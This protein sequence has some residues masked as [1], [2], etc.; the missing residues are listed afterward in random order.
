MIVVA[1]IVNLET[2][3][4]VGAFPLEYA[5]SRFTFH[6][7]TDRLG[8]VG[9]NV[10]AGIGALGA[11][12]RLM[13][14]VGDDVVGRLLRAELE[15]LPGVDCSALWERAGGSLRSC[16][17]VD[18]D[19]RGA[20]FTDL[21]DSQEIAWPGDLLDAALAGATHV[22]ATNINWACE[23]ARRARERGLRLSTDVQ[24]ISDLL[25]DA[26]NRRYLE[27]ADI[28]LFSAENLAMTPADAVEL[29][30]REY[31][32]SLVIATNGDRG[33]TAMRRGD[34]YPT[35]Q[36]APRVERVANATGAGDA[37]AAGFLRGLCAGMALEDAL[38]VGQRTAALR[39]S[40]H[41]TSW[42]GWA[43]AAG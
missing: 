5:K 23:V 16:I 40:T 22:H 10:A 20:M 28:V 42:P 13:A 21:K 6:G 25:G 1:G 36:R 35:H 24:A 37:F 33:V 12:V 30:L 4:R 14:T 9:Y 27:L 2:S 32:A 8:G 43:E 19:G 34:Q 41:T 26:Y 29:V 39:I 15:R 31:P 17:L 7:V 3:A 11:D 18:D 38:A